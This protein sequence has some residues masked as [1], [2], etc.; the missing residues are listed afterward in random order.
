MARGQ[1]QPPPADASQ[2]G[3]DPHAWPRDFKA[4]DG[5]QFTVY[6]PQI[7]QWD[8]TNLTSRAAVEVTS[9]GVTDARYGV[10]WFT[11][12][13]HV[14][15]EQR[16]VMLDDV[17]VSRVEFPTAPDQ[18]A[19][20]L[21]ALQTHF[22]VHG[23]V[24]SLDRL[25][26]A[27]AAANASKR[28]VVPTANDPPRIIFTTQPSVLVL[29]DG[30]AALRKTT[31]AALERVVNTRALLLH[32]PSTGS[33]YLG[34][35]DRWLIAPAINGPWTLAPGVPDGAIETRTALLSAQQVDIFDEDDAIKQLFTDGGVPAIYVSS[36]PAELVET[37]GEPQ[38][39]AIEGT[40]LRRVTNTACDVFLDAS[41]S[42]FVLL[43]GRWFRGPTRDGPWTY[44]PGESLPPDFARIPASDDAAE[45][46]ACVPGTPQAEEAA[47]ENDVPQTAQVN[48][49][50]A[51]FDCSYDGAPDFE[52]VDGTSLRYCVNAATPEVLCDGSY[53]A[54]QDGVWFR[55]GDPNTGW[56]CAD[57]VPPA[58]YSIPPSCPIYYVT[59]AHVYR[60]NA[61]YVWCGYTPGYLGTCVGRDGCVCW[62]TGY[63][64]KPWI[65]NAWY[66]RPWTYGFGASVHFCS[67]GFGVGIGVTSRVTLH[68]WW[69]PIAHAHEAFDARLGGHADV[70]FNNA[71]VYHRW[72]TAVVER[73]EDRVIADRRAAEANREASEHAARERAIARPAARP[74][75]VYATRDGQ[76]VRRTN[77]GT[78]EH[79][80]GGAAPRPEVQRQLEAEHSARVTGNVRA[81]RVVARPAP[82]PRPAPVVHAPQVRAPAPRPAPSPGLR[83]GS[84]RRT[85]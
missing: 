42:Y 28:V 10:A 23:K 30:P 36:D 61:N 69:G 53:Y 19:A 38:M 63:R 57:S 34:V 44:V 8:Q 67:T 65:G 75:N 58:I 71:N 18:Q 64:A 83:G 5:T 41:N 54:C 27:W 25:E 47:I 62:G 51:H 37:S 73:R 84:T 68:P 81:Q 52:P 48:R 77:A 59:Y 9:P 80:S 66:G 39:V 50:D 45:C 11:A 13:T 85:R 74:N 78:F 33:F 21:A 12:H 7:E 26:A 32:D 43:A 6:Q 31:G 16:Q 29:I 14:D 24:A 17:Q 70:H 15:K 49:A 3:D 46:L 4:D 22:P 56:V 72:N 55:S 35:C 40:G 20:W 1:D 76:V 79:T 82:A 2:A 60:S